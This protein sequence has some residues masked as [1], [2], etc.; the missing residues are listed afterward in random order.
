MQVKHVF[1]AFCGVSA[2]LIRRRQ[3]SRNCSKSST[4]SPK[5]KDHSTVA[6]STC[7]VVPGRGSCAVYVPRWRGRGS[8][9]ARGPSEGH[10]AVQV[11]ASPE[12]PAHSLQQVPAPRC[13]SILKLGWQGCCHR[14]SGCHLAR[15]GH[16]RSE[17]TVMV[18]P[19][20]SFPRVPSYVQVICS[21]LSLF[22]DHR[23]M[24]YYPS[25]NI[26]SSHGSASMSGLYVEVLALDLMPVWLATA[27]G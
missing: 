18:E 23:K 19:R 14:C 7:I 16:L 9:L 3:H 21:R 20:R 27:S 4:K 24:Y 10:A 1:A 17:G 6:S 2:G 26:W 25:S 12:S 8:S 15:P 11:P 5:A 13:H 22:R